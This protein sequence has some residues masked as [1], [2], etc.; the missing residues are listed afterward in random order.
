[1]NFENLEFKKASA[2]LITGGLGY[3][4][5][6]IAYQSFEM[7]ATA[8]YRFYNPRT[9]AHFWTA[10]SN[11][12]QNVIKNSIGN[13]D[14]PNAIGKDPLLDGWGYKYEG[15]SYK[16][17]T[18]PQYGMD[19]AVYRFFQPTKGAHFYSSNLEEVRNIITNS[20]GQQYSTDLN[21]TLAAN[22]SLIPNGWGYVF[23]GKA[24]F[25]F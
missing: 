23:E 20:V 15:L 14:L 22:T 3:K 2:D 1:M 6:G 19:T 17:L 7:Q 5:E 11:E 21:K 13:Y 16:V 18:M 10:D 24:F 12:A 4:Y 25:C 8:L 9:T